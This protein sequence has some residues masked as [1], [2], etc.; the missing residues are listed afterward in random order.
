[1]SASPPGGPVTPEG[2][3]QRYLDRNTPW[4]LGGPPPALVRL[5]G[6]DAVPQGARV[7]VPGAGYGHDA[8]AFARAGCRVVAVDLS[9]SACTAL[10]A[11]A[12][13][14][15]LRID[16]LQADVLAL[17]STF[18]G[19]F[20]FVWE[21]TCLCA[22]PPERRSDYVSVLR[23]VLKPGGRLLALLWNHGQPGGPPY[24]ITPALAR[25]LFL[26]PLVEL[27]LEPV[28]PAPVG[29]Q[30]EFLLRLARA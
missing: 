13:R 11:H 8:F 9:L 26:G 5:L 2:W 10:R 6:D 12:W 29:R 21:Q 18:D 28:P 25:E 15:G 30:N 7:L 3:E 23:R 27:G 22:L 24:D 17:P 16:T 20:D 14:A 1:V 4:D 19:T